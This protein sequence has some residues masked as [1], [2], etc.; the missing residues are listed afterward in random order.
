MINK[1]LLIYKNYILL[2]SYPSSSLI[3]V[4]SILN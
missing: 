1:V 3:I 4:G 2:L